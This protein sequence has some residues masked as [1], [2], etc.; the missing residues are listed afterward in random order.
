[1]NMH[2][3]WKTLR[4]RAVHKAAIVCLS[5]LFL[6]SSGSIKANGATLI[7]EYTFA[8]GVAD[9]VGSMNGALIGGAT[10]TGGVL[11]LNGSGYAQLSGF[12]VP[13]GPFSIS[14]DAESTG[15]TL[16]FT[17]ILSQG[18]SGAPGLYVGTHLG[19]FRLGDQFPVTPVA[20]PYDGQFHSY[21]LVSGVSGTDFYIDGLSAFT[22]AVQTVA[23][24][25]GSHTIFGEQFFGSYDEFFTGQIKDVRIY[26]GEISPTPLPPSWTLFA[27]PLFF[28]GVFGYLMERRSSSRRIIDA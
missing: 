10:A 7:H 12:A 6:L 19:T 3:R 17:E 23:P 27:A 28:L 21:L 8:S 16:P 4:W 14:F 24:Q 18:F 22:S 9:V 20:F 1:M 11:S 13:A 26:S 25:V 5:L 15:T 2:N